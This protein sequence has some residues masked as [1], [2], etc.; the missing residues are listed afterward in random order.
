MP[1]N[2]HAIQKFFGELGPGLI[3]GAADDDPSG[4]AT[5]SVSGAAFKCDALLLGGADESGQVFRAGGGRGGLAGENVG[6]LLLAA[7]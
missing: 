5:Y 7:Q 1:R 3:T 6:F 4:I 2:N